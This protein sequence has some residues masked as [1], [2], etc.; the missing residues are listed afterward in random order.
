M[1]YQC[2]AFILVADSIQVV[3]AE[4]AKLNQH[5]KHLGQKQYCS[6]VRNHFALLAL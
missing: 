2:Y 5:G 1:A 3:Q 6:Q 4:S